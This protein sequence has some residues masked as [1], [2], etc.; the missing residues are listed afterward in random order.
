MF[1]VIIFIMVDQVK[2][3]DVPKW[4]P[5]FIKYKYTDQIFIASFI[6]LLRFGDQLSY[7]V[8]YSFNLWGFYRLNKSCKLAILSLNDQHVMA[9]DVIFHLFMHFLLITYSKVHN[10]P[11]HLAITQAQK[12]DLIKVWSTQAWERPDSFQFFF[13]V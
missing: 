4:A 8:G 1:G 9:C 2:T 7:H 10:S 11:S 3:R 13:F 12:S 5:V 6:V